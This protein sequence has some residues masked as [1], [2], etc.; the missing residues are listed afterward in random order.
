MANVDLGINK[1]EKY[2]REKP[3]VVN[4]LKRINRLKINKNIKNLKTNKPN[5]NLKG[6]QS[7][8]KK[9]RQSA[10]SQIKN[11][12]PK[13]KSKLV[14][15][16]G[17][18][19]SVMGFMGEFNDRKKALIAQGYTPKEARNRAL[20]VE[21][22]GLAGEVG[23]GGTATKALFSLA[24]LATVKTGGGAAALGAYGLAG[25]GSVYAYGKGEELGEGG[26]KW[27]ADRLG[28]KVDQA[29][30]NRRL[31]I[32]QQTDNKLEE[33]KAQAGGAN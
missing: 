7:N 27:V 10:G 11:I 32:R 23:I 19:L 4:R 6:L 14:G 15:R 20:T 18:I 13:D 1:L 8:L 33:M 28:M 26:G 25:A 16:A 17:N 21:L 2:Q 5:I 30:L 3:K 9:I 31:A 12:I 29:T 22:G 24:N